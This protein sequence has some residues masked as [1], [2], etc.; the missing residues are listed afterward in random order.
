MHWGH[1]APSR[2]GPVKVT[3]AELY[4][5]IGQPIPEP[6]EIPDA[7]EHVWSWYWTLHK[8]RKPGF[9]RVAPIG[10]DE[11]ASWSMLTRTPITPAEV[12]LLVQ[13]DDE[14]ISRVN[15]EMSAQAERAKEK[16]AQQTKKNSRK[17]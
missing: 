16:Q 1:T 5:S 6:S 8:R 15:E 13:M 10:Y 3:R 12:Y 17:R 11:I 4:E 14:Y 9:E 7:I 2:E